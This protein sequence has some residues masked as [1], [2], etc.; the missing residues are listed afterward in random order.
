MI[1]LR[2]LEVVVGGRVLVRVP[3]LSLEAGS[4]T[5]IVG[6]NGSGKSTLLNTI[7]PGNS[8]GGAVDI[9]GYPAGSDDALRLTGYAP[10]EPPLHNGLTAVE[11][12]AL[13]E[14][15]WN[16]P[17]SD[18]A[19]SRWGLSNCASVT[20]GQLSTGQRR[21]LSLAMSRV[22]DPLVHGSSMSHGTPS[23]MRAS[24]RS[25]AKLR[26]SAGEA[27]PWSP[28]PMHGRTT[29]SAPACARWRINS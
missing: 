15:L 17:H 21:R 29:W 9:C 24:Q 16:R 22:H 3:R 4:V 2:N 11:H 8:G 18:D 26:F 7:G 25:V 20:A 1:E 5:A 27:G 23:T 12:L 28:P 6:P 19:L 13:L 10:A 14:A